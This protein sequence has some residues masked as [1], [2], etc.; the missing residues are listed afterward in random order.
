MKTIWRELLVCLMMGLVLP[1][2]MAS[3]G[4][5]YFRSHVPEAV[6]EE[7]EAAA[8]QMAEPLSGNPQIPV[9]LSDGEVKQMDMEEYLVGVVLA[10]MPAS[11]EGEAVKAQAVAARTYAA[12]AHLTGGKHGDG[13][14]CTDPGCCQAHISE[15]MYLKNGGSQLGV[16]KVRGAVKATLGQVLTYEG[17]LIEATYFSCS[18][19][20]T[21][22]A[23]AVWGAE[24]PYLKSVESPGEEKSDSFR[25]HVIIPKEKAEMLLGLTLPENPAQWLGEE[26]RTPGEGIFTLE[27]GGRIFK[28]TELRTLLGLKST[29]ITVH[30]DDRGLV[31]ET[32]GW[33]HR[34]GM[35]QY[36][37]DA[38]AAAGKTYEE[39]LAHYYPGTVLQQYIPP[40]E[41]KFTEDSQETIAE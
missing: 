37:A 3:L 30:A 38:M 24:F 33:G 14:V 11:F 22:D 27:I 35:S 28:G 12:K 9:L 15:Y 16:E 17:D 4:K 7:T 5:G 41:E 21:E 6:T 26:K 13:S 18:G 29:A 32:K 34:V 2:T 31:I 25:N 10:E 36:G 8:S 20:R 39:I 19:G 1:G 23:A 40:E